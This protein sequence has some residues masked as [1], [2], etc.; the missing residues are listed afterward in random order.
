[1]ARRRSKSTRMMQRL[2][3]WLVP[4]LAVLLVGLVA[5]LWMLLGS[6]GASSSNG[7]TGD[8][9]DT[10]R[11]IARRHGADPALQR[12][13]DP[14]QKQGSTFVR[15]WRFVVTDEWTAE[16]LRSDVEAEASLRGVVFTDFQ[17]T[18][19]RTTRLRVDLAVEA[20]EIFVETL[21]PKE[22]APP[23]P[24]PRPSPTPRPQPPPGATGRLAILLDDA[25]Q[26]MD[27]VE[28]GAALPGPVGF[29]V[30]PFLPS[31]AES[32]LAMHRAG[33]E[34]WLHLPMEPTGY[35]NDRPG[36]GAVF[37]SMSEDELRTTVHAALNNV[38]HVVGVNNHMGSKATADIRTM[39]WV[40][41][42]LKARGVAFL[43]SRTT[44]HSTAEDAARAQGV[45]TGRRH[46]FLDNN[47][48][49]SAIKAQLDE[50]VYQSLM[51]G[52]I[53]AIGHLDATTIKVLAEHIPSLAGKGVTLVEPSKLMR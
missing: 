35:P 39:T 53:V 21:P 52:E 48:S 47:R 33:H 29:A 49:A 9:A 20:F 45:P 19:P 14:I 43:D 51:K 22:A 16:L 36:P 5:A 6:R 26:S 41:Q 18:D 23:T 1:M 4:V 28:A 25:G 8:F 44:K 11:T 31:S 38:P 34:I 24:T 32:A 10:L 30:L 3:P 37:V 15:T 50:A 17:S 40:M 27:Q 13:D 2:R 7:A 12:E 42:E 46:V